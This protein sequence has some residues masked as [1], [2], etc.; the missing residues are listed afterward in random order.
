[1]WQK[2]H[3]NMLAVKEKKEIGAYQPV[4]LCYQQPSACHSL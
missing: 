3:R 2:S 1:V 4:A